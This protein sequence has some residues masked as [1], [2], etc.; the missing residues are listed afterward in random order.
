MK[1]LEFEK[2]L[3]KAIATENRKEQK[4][5]LRSLEASIDTP[6]PSSRKFNWSIAASILVILGLSSFFFLFNQSPS[7][8]ELYNSYFSP[9]E[10]VIEPIVRNQVNLSKRAEVFALYE[11]GEYQ[12]AIEG[13]DALILQ[14]SLSFYTVS[15]YKA[16]AHLKLNEF[17]EAKYLLQLVVDQDKE[18]RKES[19]WYLAL[20]SIKLN[21]TDTA[22]AY[23]QKLQQQDKK[24]F[25][26][27]ETEDL[28]KALN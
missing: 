25:K 9:Y 18:W 4:E 10:N 5:Y 14:D 20:I 19:L 24:T 2:G 3:K 17:D 22:L 8:D 26:K 28:L 27:K 7:I 15:F 23:L 6:E 13:F 11:Q 21:D 16:N 12:K 1:D